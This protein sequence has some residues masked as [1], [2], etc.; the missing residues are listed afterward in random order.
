MAFNAHWIVHATMVDH[1]FINDKYGWEMKFEWL[2]EVRKP[3]CEAQFTT[4]RRAARSQSCRIHHHHLQR[5][6]WRKLKVKQLW[7]MGGKGQDLG[8]WNKI[9]ARSCINL[10]RNTCHGRRQFDLYV[11][12][13]KGSSSFHWTQL[14]WALWDWQP[15]WIASSIQCTTS[16]EWSFWQWTFWNIIFLQSKQVQILPLCFEQIP[17]PNKKSTKHQKHQEAVIRVDALPCTSRCVL[18]NSISLV[19]NAHCHSTVS[20]CEFPF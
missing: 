10:Q 18:A 9:S 1:V 15:L 19:W 2:K 6:F 14:P 13:L 16:L 8:L 5:F 12:K 7:K 4:L 17:S 11:I 20:T 3:C